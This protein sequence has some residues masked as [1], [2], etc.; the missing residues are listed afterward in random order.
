VPVPLR[1]G[2]D[3]QD[4]VDPLGVVLADAQQHAGGERDGGAPGVLQHP[5]PDGRL[6]V[7]RAEVRAARLDHS[8]VAVVSSIIPI[9]ADTGLSRW[10]SSQVSTRG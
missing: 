5:Q 10:I 9:D 8:R 2:P 7:R 1:G 6:L 3:L 4:G